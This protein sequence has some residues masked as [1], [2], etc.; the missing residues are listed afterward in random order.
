LFFAGFPLAPTAAVISWHLIG[1]PALKLRK[2]FSFA[3]NHRSG[4]SIPTGMISSGQFLAKQ[5][6][7]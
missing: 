3:I 6:L 1:Y 5:D 7:P 4:E 2:R